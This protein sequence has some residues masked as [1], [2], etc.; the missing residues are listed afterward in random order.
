MNLK[1]FYNSD[2]YR[3]LLDYINLKNGLIRYQKNFLNKKQFKEFV[4]QPHKGIPLI[5]PL[6]LNTFDYQ[7][8]NGFFQIDKKDLLKIYQTKNINYKP[9]NNYFNT[10][11]IYCVNARPKKNFNKIINKIEKHNL[12]IKKK[13]HNLKKKYS[14]IAFQTRNIPH[15]GHEQILKTVIKRYG[16]LIINPIIGPKKSGDINF[17]YLDKIYKY[18]IKKKY[19]NKIEFL[20]IYSS[21]FYAGPREA[22]HHANLRYQFGIK[23]FIIGRDHAGSN[24]NYDPFDSINLAKKLRNKINVNFF[25]SYGAY[26]CTKC[27]NYVLKQCNLHK[28][29]YLKDISGTNFRKKILKKK[30][31]LHADKDLQNYIRKINSK[32][33]FLK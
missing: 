12:D 21:F 14:L 15:L 23:N 32:N 22:V 10:E 5:L 25:Y 26:Y 6:G 9:I 17:T 28:K 3:Y 29:T 27:R 18:I 20:P 13:I 7:T 2:N 16:K 8:A 24:D 4:N 33:L 30:I 31:F 19:K 11:N 1:N